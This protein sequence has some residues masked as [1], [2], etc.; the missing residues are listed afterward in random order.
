MMV[1]RARVIVRGRVQGVFFRVEA[2]TRARSLGVAGWVRNRP[3]GAV[4]AAFEGPREAVESM[5][6]WSEQGPAGARVDAV[7]VTWEPPVGD[8]GFEVR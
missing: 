2:R 6:R 8:E 3:D 4:E 5:L 1:A 7:D